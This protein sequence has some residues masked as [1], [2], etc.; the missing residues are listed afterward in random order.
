MIRKKN[1]LN[2]PLAI[3][4]ILF[5]LIVS[6]V[7]G[8]PVLVM[9]FTEESFPPTGNVE[10]LRTAPPQEEYVEIGEISLRVGSANRE[11]AIIRLRS[12]AEE[13][14]A[15]A[16]ILMG[17]R[18]RGAVAIPVGGIMMATTLQEIYVIAIKYK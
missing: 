6:C 3:L 16:I 15:D 18:N 1:D 10:V 11:N 7:S 13:L 17:E 9:R 4:L 5:L 14:G 2:K 8:P 12:K